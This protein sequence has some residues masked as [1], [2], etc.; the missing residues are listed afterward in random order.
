MSE[1]FI[2]T[3]QGQ[4]NLKLLS[5]GSD[6]QSM[7]YVVSIVLKEEFGRISSAEIVLDDGGFDNDS[8]AISNADELLVGKNIEVCIGN[9][10][11]ADVL[12]KGIVV[13]QRIRIDD[14]TRQL[15]ITAKHG[16]VKMT[17]V[18]QNRCFADKADSD[19]VKDVVGEYSLDVEI[20]D[21]S[22]AHETM[23]QY[24][25]TDWDF[26]N[27]RIEANGQMLYCS[28]KGL[29]SRVPNVSADPVLEINNGYNLINLDVEM[30]AS[31]AFDSYVS[32][33]WNYNSQSVEEEELSGGEYDSLQG[34]FKHSDASEALGSQQY[35]I[36]SDNMYT[37][38][39]LLVAQ[40]DA[41]AKRDALARISGSVSFPG[42]AMV[43][44]GDIVKL[45]CCGS[46]I[47]GNAFV[48]G[49]THEIKGNLWTTSLRMGTDGIPYAERYDNISTQPA[50]GCLPHV[51]GL[52]VG[53]VEQLSEDP[54]DE[55]R[56]MVRLQNGDD[57]TLW[58]RFAMPNAGE[59]RG[60]CFVPEIGDEVVVGF[61]N[62]NPNLA[63]VLGSLHSNSKAAP[64]EIN[65]DNNIKGIY[66]RESLKIEF[67]EEKKSV[68][69]ST[70]GG[71]VLSLSDDAKGISLEDQNGNKII[72]NDS[73][74]NISSS[75]AIKVEASRDLSEKGANVAI[76]AQQGFKATGNSGVEMSTAA[77]AV[78][79]GSIVQIN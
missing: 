42:Y 69:I 43:H 47:N 76:E 6:V 44:P 39:E 60:V 32:R 38:T 58:A 36:L 70:P 29:V 79:K 21:T 62:D 9:D 77:T 28:T 48:T 33:T 1:P 57:V 73:G 26:I 11:D 25:A 17:R 22:V 50:N 56:I 30:D 61:I 15:V 31:Q 78:L 5:E 41:N 65:D 34:N 20:E 12:F 53:M 54:Q 71:N 55:Q 46:R 66:T 10:M 45:D 52:M 37:N 74:I 59:N 51:N 63:V 72:M 4:V 3:K 2:P 19:I 23:M 16:A 18:R 8:F 75:K 67:D 64:S 7:A 14:N 24:N 68:M 40:N 13:R 35:T 27:M 49:V